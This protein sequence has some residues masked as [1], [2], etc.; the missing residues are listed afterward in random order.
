MAVISR[1]TDTA[2]VAAP[3]SVVVLIAA[4]VV[5]AGAGVVVAGA[6]TVVAGANVVS[7]SIDST[8]CL[9]NLTERS[10]S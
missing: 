1:V 6:V 4:V 8:Y 2:M 3:A 9:T 10:P 5:S 7:G